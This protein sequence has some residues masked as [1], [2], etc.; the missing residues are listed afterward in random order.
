[1]LVRV[2]VDDDDPHLVHYGSANWQRNV[3]ESIEND[4]GT[5]AEVVEPP[6]L[7]RGH[8]CGMCGGDLD[9][10]GDRPCGPGTPPL[11]VPYRDCC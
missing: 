2:S 9:V 11:G 8:A 1:M 6:P 10:H 3:I 4:N 5:T 7:V